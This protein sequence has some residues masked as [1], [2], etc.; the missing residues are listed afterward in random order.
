MA[1][2]EDCTTCKHFPSELVEGHA[3]AYHKLKDKEKCGK[4]IFI[5]VRSEWEKI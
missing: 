4:C 3:F 1:R 2:I 5:K